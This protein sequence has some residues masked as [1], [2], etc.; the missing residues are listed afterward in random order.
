MRNA[1]ADRSFNWVLQMALVHAPAQFVNLLE[2]VGLVAFG[3]LYV[4]LL[5]DM[6]CVFMP[7]LKGK[8]K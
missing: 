6:L 3:L 8:R 4:Y 5:Y 2:T 1:L 7:R